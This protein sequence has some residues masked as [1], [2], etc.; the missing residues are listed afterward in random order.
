MPK[1]RLKKKP[2]VCVVWIR[3]Q[4]DM[5]QSDLANLIGASVHTIQSIEL[6]R[7]T[8]SERFAYKIA[9]QTG[10]SPRWLRANK[11]KKPLPDPKQIREEFER[12]QA[13]VW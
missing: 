3:E 10:V 7:L 1:S 2:Q 12:A 9:E 8:L 6:G 11:L 13:G 4:L 5:T